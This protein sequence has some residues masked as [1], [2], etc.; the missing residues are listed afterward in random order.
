MTIHI[1]LDDRKTLSTIQYRFLAELSTI[2]AFAKIKGIR[3][4][5]KEKGL[6]SEE[7]SVMILWHIQNAFSSANY[8]GIV[9]VV[10]NC[11]VNPYLLN[12]IKKRGRISNV[13][14]N[15]PRVGTQPGFMERVL[16]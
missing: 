7:L 1:E 10:K 12:G 8:G 15:L 14:Q 2:D 11:K 4:E 9:D 6:K 3:D 16:Q 5:I 13:L